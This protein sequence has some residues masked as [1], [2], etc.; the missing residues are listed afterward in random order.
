VRKNITAKKS[1]RGGMLDKPFQYNGVGR[2]KH[3]VWII[4]TRGFKGAHFAA[5]PERIPEICIKAGTSERGCCSRCGSPLKR[6]VH[7]E[8]RFTSDTK[9]KAKYLSASG[10]VRKP[11]IVSLQTIGWQRTCKCK[12]KVIPSV[13]LDPFAGTGRSLVV[14]KKLGR[15]AIGIELSKSYIRKFIMPQIGRG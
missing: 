4:P 15:N 5:F 1:Y 7:K 6:I 14:A 13:V 3:S 11:E 9:R 8:R 12:S 10:L 2:M